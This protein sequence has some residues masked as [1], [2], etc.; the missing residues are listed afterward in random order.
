M[1]SE[2]IYEYVVQGNYGYGY[3]DLTAEDTRTA[4]RQQLRDYR[5]NERNAAHRIVVR[6]TLREV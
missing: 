1:A 5:E 2:F 4:A 3:E 6:R